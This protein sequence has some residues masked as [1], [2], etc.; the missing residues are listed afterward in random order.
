MLAP[1]TLN[2]IA[3]VVGETPRPVLDVDPEELNSSDDDDE[4]DK[5]ASDTKIKDPVLSQEYE[6]LRLSKGV[7][8]FAEVAKIKSF[9]VRVEEKKRT[10]KFYK[11]VVADEKE[12]KRLETIK[13]KERPV[14]VTQRKVGD[15][16]VSVEEYK[17]KHQEEKK[18]L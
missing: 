2:Q 10:V 4:D 6:A 5:H 12:K 15:Q 16:V 8:T 11:H 13:A 1:K 3:T 14:A 18:E 9:E 17:K 7:M